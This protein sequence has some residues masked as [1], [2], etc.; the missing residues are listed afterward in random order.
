MPYLNAEKGTLLEANVASEL[1][2]HLAHQPEERR[3]GDQQVDR[4]LVLADLSQGQGA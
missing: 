1:L 2:R 3:A 4:S